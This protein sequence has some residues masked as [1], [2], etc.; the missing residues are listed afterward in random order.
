[1]NQLR[2]DNATYQFDLRQSVAPGDYAIGT[3]TPHCRPCFANDSRM[4]M[5]YS[6]GS[7]CTDRPLVDVDSDLI[8]ITRPATAAPTGKYLP[9]PPCP[10]SSPA[11]CLRESLPVEDTR[12]NHPPC[13]LRGTGWNRWEW[14]CADPQERVMTPFDTLID[15][16]IVVKDNH[17]PLVPRPLDQTVALPPGKHDA[18]SRG[19]PNW[20]PEC[21][22]GGKDE[23]LSPLPTVSWR[24]CGELDRIQN[25][26]RSATGH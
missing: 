4:H 1:M 17:R 3:P 12:L 20:M 9:T 15:T 11:D 19:A 2:Y 8:G 7:V 13:T 21:G 14:L 5:G 26:C 10:L 23:F 16:S 25:G 6:G 22:G 18:P 24:T